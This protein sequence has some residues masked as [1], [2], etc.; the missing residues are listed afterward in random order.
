AQ[1]GWVDPA[2]GSETSD[3]VRAAADKARA[4]DAEKARHAEFN[5]KASRVLGYGAASLAAVVCVSRFWW[6]PDDNLVALP[7]DQ[8]LQTTVVVSE[9]GLVAVLLIT[10][11]SQVPWKGT[12]AM[13]R[14][15][16]APLLA[17]LACCVATIFG[18]AL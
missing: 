4:A 12:D 2:A 8:A 11:L 6:V 14:G 3:A 10:V 5:D 7:G 1:V 13:A 17:A 9:F 16:A 15:F 18:A